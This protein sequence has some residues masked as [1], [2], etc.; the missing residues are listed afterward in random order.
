VDTIY[1]NPP[2]R[3]DKAALHELLDFWLSRLTPAGTAY[4]VV[5]KHLCADSL[6]RWLREQGHPTDRIAALASGPRTCAE[7]RRAIGPSIA[8]GFCP[9]H[10]AVCKWPVCY[11]EPP[12]RPRCPAD[13]RSPMREE[14]C[15]DGLPPWRLGIAA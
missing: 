10:C 11:R 8:R 9:R 3:V 13:T 1:P 4:L 2:I 12:R 14:P 15:S 6:A 7:L 5:Q